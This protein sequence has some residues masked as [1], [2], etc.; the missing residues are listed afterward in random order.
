VYGAAVEAERQ[1]RLG[2][3][4][5]LYRLAFRADDNIERKFHALTLVDD[6]KEV[7]DRRPEADLSF[8]FARTVQVAADYDGTRTTSTS[9]LTD[10]LLGSIAEIPFCRQNGPGGEEVPAEPQLA[11][12]A[13]DA[14]RPCHFD[15]LPVEVVLAVLRHLTLPVREAFFPRIAALE[16]GFARLSRRGR[17]DS[18]EQTL[19]RSI[20]ER[21][22]R[23]PQV[24]SELSF[25]ALG[26]KYDLDYRRM[27]LEQA[28]LRTDGCFIAVQ[29]Y[30][31]RG[32]AETA[33]V[34]PSWVVTFHRFLRC[35]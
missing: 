13:Q 1:G 30:I 28:R 21:V 25:A 19:W 34:D 5:R 24:P 2:E 20:C 12:H 29:R 23:C 32:S 31:R 18:L 14:G 10:K 7:A 17:L 27:W 6:S 26:R 8:A 11:Y 15:R 35:A 22:Y 9:Q 33:F 16:T 3:A 4:T